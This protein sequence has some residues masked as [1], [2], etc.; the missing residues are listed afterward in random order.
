MSLCVDSA[1]VELVINAEKGGACR[2]ELCSNLV[3][4]GTE[5]SDTRRNLVH[6]G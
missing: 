2:L 6:F 3:E 5:G 4:G 1:S